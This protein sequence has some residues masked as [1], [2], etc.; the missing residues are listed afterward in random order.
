MIASAGLL[1]ADGY[2]PSSGKLVTLAEAGSVLEFAHYPKMLAALERTVEGSRQLSPAELSQIES[3]IAVGIDGI[4]E[5]ARSLLR[6][7]V[8]SLLAKAEK[9][10]AIP[11]AKSRLK[12]HG[13]LE[14][15]L[16]DLKAQQ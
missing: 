2:A 11:S 15:T 16:A 5:P 14:R 9:L 3:V 1:W 13:T 12:Q 6:K 7:Q 4:P 8:E 10:L